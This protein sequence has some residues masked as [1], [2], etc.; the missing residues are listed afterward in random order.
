MGWDATPCVREG[1]SS[2]AT[3][4]GGVPTHQHFATVSTARPW[5][6]RWAFRTSFV[7]GGRFA[8]RT[9]SATEVTTSRPARGA[10]TRRWRSQSVIATVSWGALTSTTSAGA[11][12]GG[13][14]RA[15]TRL[16]GSLTSATPRVRRSSAGT[17]LRG[18]G[19]TATARSCARCRSR[20]PTLPTTR[21]APSPRS[22]TRTRPR[23]RRA[24]PWCMSRGASSTARARR[25]WRATSPRGPWTRSAPAASCATPLTLHSG[26]SPPRPATPSARS[27]R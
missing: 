24:S 1:R 23:R 27:P 19:T 7:R 25:T 12:C 10:T 21:S 11:S 17:A 26:A 2:S 13:I 18:S 15:P 5:P 4:A 16:T 14:A 3:K 22:R 6:T 8:A 9:W 20:S